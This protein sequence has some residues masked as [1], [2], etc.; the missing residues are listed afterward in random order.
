M[1]SKVIGER[2]REQRRRAGLTQAELG[3][4][5]GLSRTAVTNIEAGKQAI[6]VEALIGVAR[7]VRCD[8]ADLLPMT[9][10]EQRHPLVLGVELSEA[11]PDGWQPQGVIVLVR[12]ID[13]DGRRRITHLEGGDVM[14]WEGKSMIDLAARDFGSRLDALNECVEHGPIA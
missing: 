8:L 2:V 11:L 3:E 14:L 4:A 1:M 5:L 7:R 10:Q 6:T 13:A 9:V 12:A